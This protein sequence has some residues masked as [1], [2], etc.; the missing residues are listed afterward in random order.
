MARTQASATDLVLITE[1]HA[2][3]PGLSSNGPCLQFSPMK[4]GGP[5]GKGR[6]SRLAAEA[7]PQQKG[8]FQPST[9]FP[10]SAQ[11]QQ[12]RLHW[13]EG[14]GRVRA[15]GRQAGGTK[16]VTEFQQEG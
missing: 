4:G 13:D 16:E 15:T 9:L 6:G 5:Q 3:S 1:T 7:C 12:D 14:A 2:V 10:V 11:S 8:P